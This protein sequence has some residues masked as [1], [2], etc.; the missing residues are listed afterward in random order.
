MILIQTNIDPSPAVQKIVET[1]IIGSLLIIVTFILMYTIYCHNKE[2]KEER[3]KREE[4]LKRH[5]DITQNNIDIL[6]Q[7]SNRFS[8]S[9]DRNTQVLNEIKGMIKH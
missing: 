8:D 6:Q 7:I 3:D 9:L 2:R 5:E 4:T 1:G